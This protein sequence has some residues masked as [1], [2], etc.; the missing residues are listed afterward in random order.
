[1]PTVLINITLGGSLVEFH[2]D[3]GNGNTVSL[4]CV[5]GVSVINVL[6]QLGIPEDKPIMAILNGDLVQPEGYKQTR[7]SDGDSLSL[8][9]PIQAG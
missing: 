8:V 4:T 5:D 6:Q 7:M 2:P 9:Q 3:N 1:M